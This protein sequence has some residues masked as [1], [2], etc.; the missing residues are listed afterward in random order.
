M[1]AYSFSELNRSTQI[2]IIYGK[3]LD[4]QKMGLF[5]ELA[6]YIIDYQ[7]NP[8][9]EQTDSELYDINGNCVKEIK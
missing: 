3:L 4:V 6:E 2:D 9:Y 8:F 1:K 7:V 5:N